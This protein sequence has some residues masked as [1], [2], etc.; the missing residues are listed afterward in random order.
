MNLGPI[1]ATMR[2]VVIVG[3][4]LALILEIS[5]QVPP[6]CVGSPTNR[7]PE[8]SDMMVNCDTMDMEVS[9][10]LCPVYN[11]QYN[12][13]L[14]VL[15]NQVGSAE[16]YG[17]PDWTATPP[18]LRFRFPLNGSTFSACHHKLRTTSTVGT[19]AFAAFSDVPFVNISGTINSVDPS[20]GQI[21]Y[22]E[23]V[24]YKYSCN[25]PMQYLLN[26]TELA[27]SGVKLAIKDNNGS[28]ITTLRMLL[29]ATSD[30]STPLIIPLY[31]LDLKTKIYVAV[32]AT[33]LTDR[34]HLLLDRCYATTTPYPTEKNHYDL[35]VGCPSDAQTKI[36]KNGEAQ[37]AHFSFEAF[38]FVEHKN[39]TV[40]IFYLHCTT[41]LC[42]VDKC[43]SLKPDCQSPAS[44]R[45]R[46]E[47][48]SEEEE[49]E[50]E[51]VPSEATISS[52]PIGVGRQNIVETEASSASHES[53]HEDSY[54]G[55]VVAV[56]VCLTIIA[57]FI[58]GLTIYLVLYMRREKKASS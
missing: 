50:D 35:F 37:E 20:A 17:T 28:F 46:R 29:Y 1:L 15:N 22:R 10:Y 12:E 7:P 3:C 42:E 32:K 36:E 56:I 23:Q 8:N 58:T 31:G 25:Y 57:I 40:S 54:S 4:F 41:R 6:D 55:P 39:Q 14:M 18:V 19:G 34:F 49:D 5:A 52:G 51:E 38:R 24:M 9:I 44:Q 30:H 26:N 21:T 13:S 45:V 2:L 33:K 47:A 48:P 11:A 16:C 27:V 43:S 53:S